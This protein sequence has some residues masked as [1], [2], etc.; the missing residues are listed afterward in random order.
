M[1]S[2]FILPFLLCSFIA[3]PSLANDADNNGDPGIQYEN[4][5]EISQ[6]L[7]PKKNKSSSKKTINKEIKENNPADYY[8]RG[9]EAYLQFT[10]KG[11]KEAIELFD[12]A[13]EK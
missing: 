12:Q 2:N 10:V 8:K 5:D 1:R 3:F 11:F 9:R 7:Q 13:I 4:E 6:V